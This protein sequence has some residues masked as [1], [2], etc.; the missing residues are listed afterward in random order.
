MISD[1]LTSLKAAPFTILIT[2]KPN[3][4]ASLFG[5]AQL[6]N[7]RLHSAEMAQGSCSRKN[8]PPSTVSSYEPEQ[9]VSPE[10]TPALSDIWPD[11]NTPAPDAPVHAPV[12]AP[13]STD[14][15]FQQFMK[16]YLEAQT[17][18]LIQAEL[19][20]QPLKACFPN[21]YYGNTHMDCYWSCQ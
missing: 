5:E 15:L 7:N 13:A 18:A 9:P 3:R 4:S 6:D 1:Q 17:P 2:S 21:L 8:V 20:E 10:E 14:K 12:P 19:W 16:A 11:E